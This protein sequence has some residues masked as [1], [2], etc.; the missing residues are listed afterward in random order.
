M[1]TLDFYHANPPYLDTL[2][3]IETLQL[4]IKD[5]QMALKATEQLLDRMMVWLQSGQSNACEIPS[6]FVQQTK[7]ASSHEMPPLLQKEAYPLVCFWTR[8]TY[9][10]CGTTNTSA[11]NN[12][13]SNT[14]NTP[15]GLNNASNTNN[16]TSNTN[17][18]ASDTDNTPDGFEA[19]DTNNN[20]SNT[21]STP[22][23]VNNASNTN[24]NLQN[25]GSAPDGVNN[26]LNTNNA[27]D[28][29]DAPDTNNNALNT[30]ST[31]DDINNMSNTNAT[32]NM[33]A[34]A[35]NSASHPTPNWN[36]QY[37]RYQ[38]H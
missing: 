37:P 7:L 5:Q 13:T 20:T 31:P 14:D 18:N 34:S 10:G 38:H 29:F 22:D 17:N 21:D 8:L 16:N 12:N 26:A 19:P 9:T 23:G 11:A 30:G 4:E 25:T 24:N 33:N 1:D 3:W 28:D 36:S 6:T 2:K 15:D 27:P 35:P 32:R